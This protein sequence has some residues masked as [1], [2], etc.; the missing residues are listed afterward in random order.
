MVTFIGEVDN[1]SAISLLTASFSGRLDPVFPSL[2]SYVVGLIFYATHF[3]ECFFAAHARVSDDHS[4]WSWIDTLGGGSHAVW[5]G[6][7][8]LAIS[9]HRAALN[10]LEN[11]VGGVLKAGGCPVSS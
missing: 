6:F 11:G 1:H 9:Q 7:I 2:V 8:V 4:V 10:S 5:H 3:P